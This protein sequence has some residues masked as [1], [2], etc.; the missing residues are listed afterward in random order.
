MWKTHSIQKQ[1]KKLKFCSCLIIL[2]FTTSALFSGP[3]VTYEGIGGR[4]GDNLLAY[5]HAKWVAYR[6]RI[7]LIY[8]PFP[9]FDALKLEEIELK[10][11]QIREKIEK[12]VRLQDL[13][14]LQYITANTLFIVPYFPE[15]DW[16]LKKE[17][18][19]GVF[20]VDW[21]D[22]RF[23]KLAWEAITP[24][25]NLQLV[26]CPRNKINI[27]L[28]IREGGGFDSSNLY[29]KNPLKVPPLR[30]YSKCLH[31]AARQFPGKELYC[32]VFTDARHPELLVK[33]LRKKIPPELNIVLDYRKGNNFHD[34]NVLED[35]FSFL[36]F[37][38]LIRPAS[39]FSLVPCLLHDFAQVYFPLSYARKKKKIKID[40]IQIDTDMQLYNQC[41][42]R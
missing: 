10:E 41:L 19:M 12:C 37:D 17:K 27:A 18:W 13:S 26:E 9:Y 24:K 28:H 23:R 6:Y 36:H 20:K 42:A 3:M 11:C 38:I 21:K 4:F 35:F 2:F 15:L 16:E 5:L 22:V 30:F 1:H 31:M 14:Q 33:K 40:L 8:T 7:P 29:L 32:F 34:A 39:N 25:R